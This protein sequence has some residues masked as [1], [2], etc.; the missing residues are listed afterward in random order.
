[1][2][3]NGER[4]GGWGGGGGLLDPQTFNVGIYHVVEPFSLL[5]LHFT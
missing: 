3:S 4:T 1:M 2:S 5:F